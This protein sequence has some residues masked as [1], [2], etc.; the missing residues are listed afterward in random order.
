MMPV[1]RSVRQLMVAGTPSGSQSSE[2]ETPVPLL[3]NPQH[4]SATTEQ[5]TQH[6]SATAADTE[7]LPTPPTMAQVLAML[8]QGRQTNTLLL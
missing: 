6:Q 5:A 3:P 1:T 2:N 4:P 8:D 7:V